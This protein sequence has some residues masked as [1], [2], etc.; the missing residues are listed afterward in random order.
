MKGNIWTRIRK[1]QKQKSQAKKVKRV[2]SALATVNL[3]D[4]ARGFEYKLVKS[5]RRTL[6][7]EIKN[8]SVIVRSPLFLPKLKPHSKI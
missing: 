2:K 6:S 7:V 1:S 3:A 8:G 4:A 5:N